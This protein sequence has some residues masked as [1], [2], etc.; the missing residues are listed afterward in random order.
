MLL[1]TAAES[2]TE[3]GLT[4]HIILHEKQNHSRYCAA[5]LFIGT[6]INARLPAKCALRLKTRAFTLR[7]L[8]SDGADCLVERVRQTN[9]DRKEE[10]KKRN[11]DTEKL[12]LFDTESLRKCTGMSRMHACSP[13]QVN[14]H[15]V[16]VCVHHRTN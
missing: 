15:E 7:P 3:P 10:K 9:R 4:Q 16:Q 5:M 13:H 1:R 12:H 11:Q 8:L 2:Y 6:V 14:V